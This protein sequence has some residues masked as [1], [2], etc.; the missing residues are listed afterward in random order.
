MLAL[1]LTY[2][3]LRC[4]YMLEYS[5]LA[6]LRICNINKT[7]LIKHE[8]DGDSLDKRIICYRIPLNI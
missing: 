6:A 4:F 2:F 1:F 5:Y 7:K 8:K 3:P